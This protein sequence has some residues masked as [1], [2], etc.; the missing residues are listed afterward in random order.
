MAIVTSENF[1]TAD[2]DVIFKSCDN[3]LFHIHRRNLEVQARGFPSAEIDTNGEVVPITE[4]SSTLELFFRYIYPQRHPNIDLL[5][6]EDLFKLAEAAEKYEFFN[7]MIICNARLKQLLPERPAELFNYGYKH[8]YPDISNLAAP[9]LLDIP[10]DIIVVTLSPHLVVPWVLYWKCW[11]RAAEAALN[12]PEPIQY[13]PWGAPVQK[14]LSQCPSC[15][16]I[17]GREHRKLGGDQQLSQKSLQD[18]LKLSMTKNRANLSS[19]DGEISDLNRALDA[20]P[21]FSTFL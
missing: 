9:L 1:R 12:L 17:C 8:G 6:F 10:L 19:H 13:D 4:D 15:D 2:A 7:L 3:V 5:P 11:S 14:K 21:E 20:V 16:H 18:L